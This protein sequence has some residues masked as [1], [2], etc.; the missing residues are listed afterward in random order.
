M[1]FDAV[2]PPASHPPLQATAASAPA[3]LGLGLD[4]GGTSTRWALADAAGR[5]HA[6]GDLPGFT[7][8]LLGQPHGQQAAAEVMAALAARVRGNGHPVGRPLVLGPVAAVCAGVTG[9][10]RAG[11]ALLRQMLA[12]ALAVPGVRIEITSDIEMAC[13]VAFAPGAGFLVYAGTGSIAGH[14]DAGGQFHRAGGRGGLIDDGGSAHWIAR[15]ALR[16]IWRAEDAEPGAWRRSGMARRV[17]ADIA[18]EA[19]EGVDL[20]NDLG[21]WALTRHWIAR[22]SRGEIGLLARA[23]AAADGPAGSP[24]ADADA[25]AI[26]DEA[27]RELARLA[28]A[29]AQRFGPRPVALAGRAFLLS[30]RLAA[31]MSAALPDTLPVTQAPLA[32]ESTAAGAA[33][34]AAR[35]MGEAA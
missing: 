27:G 7:A 4:V 20:D 34:R 6:Q 13:Q 14:V 10:D 5:L 3:R 12:K 9:T 30:P 23:V 31:A 33:R 19:G 11:G 8:A 29:L 22:A 26:L 2:P 16:R 15:Q 17:L 1:A 28:L 25:A 24:L 35:L 32:E 18:R 21:D